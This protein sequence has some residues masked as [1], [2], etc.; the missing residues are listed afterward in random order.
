MKFTD[1][2]LIYQGEKS[3]L[4]NWNTADGK[5]FYWKTDWLN[6]AEDMTGHKALGKIE[7]STGKAT[8]TD[9]EKAIVKHLNK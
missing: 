8:K 9:A 3:G 4:H 1:S 2:D 5:S 7:T 6:I